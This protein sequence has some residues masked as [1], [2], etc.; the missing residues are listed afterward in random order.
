MKKWLRRLWPGASAPSTADP[1]YFEEAKRIWHEF[2]PPS[3]Q[4]STIQGE[5]LRAV[6]KLRDE[7]LRNGNGNWDDG[8]QLLLQFLG[9]HLSDAKVFGADQVRRSR[10]ILERLAHSNDPELDEAPYDYLCDRSEEHTS[11]LQSH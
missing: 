9:K 10:A 8:F 2:V 7:A 1:D 11:E 5:L 3:G 4:A 6:E